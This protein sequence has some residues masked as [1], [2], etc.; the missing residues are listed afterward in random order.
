[1]QQLQ[2][3]SDIWE[4]LKKTKN[5]LAFSGGVDSCALFFMLL[6]NGVEFD[7]AIVDHN[8][9][10]SSKDEV[11][12]AKELAKIHN[13]KI[14]LK[15]IHLSKSNFEKS[16]RDERYAFFSQIILENGYNTLLTAHHLGDKLEWFFMRFIRGAGAVEMS[17]FS[18]KENYKNY[19]IIRPL[20]YFTKEELLDYL[21]QKN[22]KYF[23]DESNFDE[24][25]ERNYFRKHFSLPLLEKY[26]DGIKRSFM[27]LENDKNFLL[28]NEYKKIKELYVFERGDNEIRLI[29]K[30][31]KF[32]K[33]VLTRAQREEIEKN[34]NTVISGKIAVGKNEKF[35]FI[36]PYVDDVVMPKEFKEKCRVAK[37]PLHVRTYMYKEKIEIDE[38]LHEN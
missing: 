25:Y 32:F 10:E 33:I 27:A 14:F 17:G 22:I 34:K 11:A 2:K 15:S 37:I 29:S 4:D 20:I 5:L 7:I 23:V 12:Y 28:K 1:M 21:T 13:K 9:R 16:A 18:Q 8:L 24:K 19:Q 38:V 35:V 26:K 36:T 3:E 30:I 6:E 31:L